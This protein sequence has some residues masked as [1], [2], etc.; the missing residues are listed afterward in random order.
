M[1]KL[2]GLLTR[3]V[4]SAPWRIAI[5]LAAYALMMLFVGL[6]TSPLV[7]RLYIDQIVFTAIGDGWL[8]G[9]VPYR[10]LFDHKGP[11]MYLIQCA[12]LLLAPGKWGIFILATACAATTS[13][14]LYRCGRVTRTPTWTN[15][16]ALTCGFVLYGLCL[17]MGN[18]VE[19]WSL[20]FQCLA[21]LL[22]LRILTV[23]TRRVAAA[24][25]VCGLCFGATAMIRVNNDNIICGACIGMAIFLIREG[26]VRELWRAA[27]AFAGGCAA[28]IAP[29]IVYFAWEGALANMYDSYI[30]FNLTY[31]MHWLIPDS[32]EE[33]LLNIDAMVGC[34]IAPVAAW[35]YD[36]RRGAQLFPTTAAIC[37]I[38]VGVF[39]RG[40]YY[41]H[42]F[43]MALPAGVLAVQLAGSIRRGLGLAAALA[44]CVPYAIDQRETPRNTRNEYVMAR[45][46]GGPPYS[47]FPDIPAENIATA[48]LDSV[49]TISAHWCA[50]TLL[51]TGHFPVGRYFYMQ[52]DF[53]NF[54]ATVRND[55]LNEFVKANPLYVMS[56]LRFDRI[57]VFAGQA[58]K[59][60]LV[61]HD[62]AGSLNIYLYRRNDELIFSQGGEPRR[63]VKR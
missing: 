21:L 20:P 37:A 34:F 62:T 49:Y 12:G 27:G 41:T 26:R 23:K 52:D 13:E 22:C 57:S 39:I 19:E 40:P 59:Y 42:Y 61:A 4:E 5:F 48:E 32:F 15:V 8:H 17:W 31:K 1:G 11:L 60:T 29:F 51:E 18:T 7:G 33:Y 46:A 54:N 50:Y 24:A 25:F 30:R 53:Q 3:M 47:F 56:S 63:R 14:L 45:Q 2:A 43:F 35:F 36:R 6:S 38:T 10:D 9:L 55:I 28:T 44:V 16:A 58:E